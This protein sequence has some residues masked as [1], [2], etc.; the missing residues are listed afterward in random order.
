MKHFIV[1]GENRT[2][3]AYPCI[4]AKDAQEALEQVKRTGGID[5]FIPL[6]VIEAKEG[7]TSGDNRQLIQEEINELVE[8]AVRE[9]A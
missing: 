8:K 2:I 1:I 6:K 9:E 5:R 4:N 3:D 7:G